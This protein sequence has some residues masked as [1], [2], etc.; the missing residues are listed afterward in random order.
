MSAWSV[1]RFWNEATVT[2]HGGGYG[3]ALDGRPV[4]TPSKA[5]LIMPTHNM[6][7]AAA[8]EWG[9]VEG[10]VD[11]R[12]MPV[13]RSAN[14]AIDKVT[15]QHGEVADLIAEY[16]G[17]DLLCYRA[18][19]PEALVSAQNDGWNPML[20]WARETLNVNLKQGPG[21]VPVTQDIDALARL[22]AMVHRFDAFE[23]A[24]VHDLVSISGSLILGLAVTQGHLT[25][26][27]AWVLSRIDEDWQESE[28]G[29]DELA[30]KLAKSKSVAFQHAAQF[31]A[32]SQG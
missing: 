12:T 6:A 22:S 14:A 21:I 31:Y 18:E 3:V 24:A 32:L 29:E 2:P 27:S 1:K 15:H 7:Q 11:P 28:W 9:A 17:S 10:K 20:D 13:T 30:T 4:R 8:D 19:W 23:L 25:P 26:D 16:G 5:A